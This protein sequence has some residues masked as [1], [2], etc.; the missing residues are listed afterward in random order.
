MYQ[1]GE[2]YHVYNQS[3]GYQPI[4]REREN[5][6]FFLRKLRTHILPVAD[7]LC[8]CLMPDHFHLMLVP[9]PEGLA[10]SRG[11]RAKRLD[12]TGDSPA[13]QQRISH[14]FRILLS[15]Y[16]RA[17]N[18]R[19]KTRGALF[20]ASTR[21]KPAYVA[22]LREPST[23]L[24][25][26][27]AEL[28]PYLLTCFHYIHDNPVKDKLVISPTDWEFS[29]ARDYAGLR[30]GTVCNYQLTEELIGIPPPPAPSN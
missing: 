22:F 13:L 28:V 16:T 3:N 11:V 23:Q 1:E 21:K 2:V 20:R 5:Y 19:Y 15:S 6:L 14:E 25:L 24:G 17:M 27:L 9:K 18:R 12:E 30:P 26:S 7:V 8:Y 29:S 10:A 4:F